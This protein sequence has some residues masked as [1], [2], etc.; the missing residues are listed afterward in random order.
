VEVNQFKI[1]RVTPG[2][3]IPIVDE[4]TLS[5]VP[6]FYLLL[7]WNFLDFMIEK[8]REFLLSGGKFIVPEPDVR[9]LGAE[10][11]GAEPSR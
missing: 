10:V 9:V 6:D 4:A 3:E 5:Q 7:S 8:Y 11:L 2:N 1:G